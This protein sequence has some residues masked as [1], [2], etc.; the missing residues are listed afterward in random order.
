M[1]YLGEL[2]EITEEKH[3]IGFIHNMPFDET[4]GLHKTQAELEQTGVLVE[5]VPEPSAEE[6]Y[7]PT[8][9]FVNP[10]T[11]DVWYEYEPIPP[12]KEELM[13]QQIDEMSV[14][15]AAILG[16]AE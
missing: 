1:V 14:A 13:Q 7:Q 16:G 6:G 10:V 9:I 2:K 15:M 5:S 12:T 11:K 3:Q 4:Y 8:G